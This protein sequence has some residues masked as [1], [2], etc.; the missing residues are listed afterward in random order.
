MCIRDS[1]KDNPRAMVEYYFPHYATSECADF[2]I[3]WAFLVRD[4]PVFKGFCQWGRALAKS[5]WNNILIP[6]SYK[7]LDVYKRQVFGFVFVKR[8]SYFTVFSLAGVDRID[9]IINQ[10]LSLI[11]I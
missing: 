10:Y 8:N 11:H 4:N 5:V 1:Y 2:Q 3:E 9:S 6:V 7:H